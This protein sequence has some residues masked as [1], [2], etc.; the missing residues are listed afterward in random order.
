MEIRTRIAP[1]P[2]GKPHIGTIYSALLDYA[3][4][5]KK[6]GR[7]LIRIEDTDRERFVE[8]AEKALYKALDWFGLN[9]DESPRKG[10]RHDPYRQSE[11]LE[12]Y[13]RY[14]QKLIKEGSAYYCFCSK[15][16]LENLRKR[17][18]KQ[19]KPPKYDKFCFKLNP[20]KAI[21]KVEK[22]EPYVVR[23]NVP[24]NKT[25]VVNDLIRGKIKFD[26]N[27]VDDCVLLKSDGYPTYH[28]AA[29]VDDCLMK[30]SHI[31]RGEEWLSSSPKHVLLWQYFGW[32]MPPIVH[33]PTLRAQD[34]SK[35]SKRKGHTNVDWYKKQGFLPE[36]ILNFL[37]LLGWS[38]P[39][40]KEVFSLKEFI[41]YFDLA[42]LSPIGPVF[43]EEKLRWLNGVYIRK[44][45]DQQLAKLLKPYLEVKISDKDLVKL[46]SITKERIEVLSDIKEMAFFLKPLK[47]FDKKLVFAQAKKDKKKITNLVKRTTENLKKI[48]ESKW[49][50]GNLEKA[51]RKLRDEFADWKTREVFMIIRVIATGRQVSPPLFESMEILGK[52]RTVERFEKTRKLLNS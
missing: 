47:K 1:S 43:N 51:L 17:Q 20:K 29:T 23:L 18:Q 37:A 32:K 39:K 16:R 52:K 12:I 33:T 38:H 8:G 34:K 24:Q 7:F 31:V 4:A 14:A 35:L 42:D 25:I 19:G 27:T 15:K 6:K 41:K 49:S 44:M 13:K 3:F 9:E 50:A 36:A 45:P 48:P 28:L 46:A 40:G 10:G 22:G 30:I 26:S 11:R 21:G 2:T 5:K